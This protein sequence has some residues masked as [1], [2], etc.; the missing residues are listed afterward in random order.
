MTDQA[1]TSTSGRD[2]FNPGCAA[3]CAVVPF[4]S[5]A[6]VE[7]LISGGPREWHSMGQMVALVF[8]YPILC[9]IQGLVVGSVIAALVRKREARQK[10]LNSK[11][12]ESQGTLTKWFV[13]GTATA[14]A[15][16]ATYIVPTST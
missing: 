14:A 2:G 9:V 7:I 11:D 4:L 12:I 13:I 10:G 15:V 16:A 1:G 3:A 8:V 6:E 5:L